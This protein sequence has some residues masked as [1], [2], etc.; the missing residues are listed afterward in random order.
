MET[1]ASD[2]RFNGYLVRYCEQNINMEPEGDMEKLSIEIKPSGKRSASSFVLTLNVNIHDDERKFSIHLV[3]D[4]FFAFRDDINER[5]LGSY[6]LT[7]APA[8]LFPYIRA[9]IAMMSSMSGIG[10]VKLPTLNLVGLKKE[11]EDNIE[12]DKGTDA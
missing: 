7:N 11:L 3:V 9:Y 10:T 8:I 1:K 6:F 12:T 2:F 4:G 5:E